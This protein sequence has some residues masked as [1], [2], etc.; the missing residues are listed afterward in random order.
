MLQTLG[1]V[2]T[3]VLVLASLAVV[4]YKLARVWL[5][6]Q[7]KSLAALF[8]MSRPIE[9][10]SG[11]SDT[12]AVHVPVQTDQYSSDGAKADTADTDAENTGTGWQPRLPRYPTEEEL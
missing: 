3:C 8:I 7:L 4:P 12:S 11:E 6:P 10:A 1:D 5:A 9:D 2:I